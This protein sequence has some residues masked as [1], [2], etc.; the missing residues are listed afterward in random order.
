M[1]NA[2][3]PITSRAR[4]LASRLGLFASVSGRSVSDSIRSWS[5]DDD[6][7]QATAGAK[8]RLEA[9]AEHDITSGRCGPTFTSEKWIS[10]ER[11]GARNG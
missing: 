2:I 7:V 10:T 9:Q 11:V 8:P 4:T 5:Q 6:I 1:K 3:T